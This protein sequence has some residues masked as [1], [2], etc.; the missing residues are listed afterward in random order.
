MP[1]VEGIVNQRPVPLR[2]RQVEQIGRYTA[3]TAAGD[4]E[5][6]A[7]TESIGFRGIC[8]QGHQF[9][10]E[11]RRRRLHH[12]GMNSAKLAFSSFQS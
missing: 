11:E 10:I 2:P 4:G 6:T 3:I 7:V 5:V 12:V 9:P 1:I 8:S